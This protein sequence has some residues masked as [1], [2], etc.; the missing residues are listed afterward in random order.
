MDSRWTGSFWKEVCKKMNI[1][2]ALTTA[3]HPQADGLYNIVYLTVKYMHS[4]YTFLL[5]FYIFY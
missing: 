1:Q 2:R 3:Y 4:I 5:Y